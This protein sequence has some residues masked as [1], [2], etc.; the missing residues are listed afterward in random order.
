ML[1]TAQ[2]MLQDS[3]TKIELLRMQIIKVSQGRDGERDGSHGKSF[4]TYST[5]TLLLRISNSTQY[6]ILIG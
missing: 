3:R 5:C 4:Y 6:K 2:Q 1:S